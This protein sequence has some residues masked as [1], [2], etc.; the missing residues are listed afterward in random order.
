[1]QE[2]DDLDKRFLG[3][4]LPGHIGKGD[5]GLLFHV[6]LGLAFADAAQSAA[7]ALGHAPHEQAEQRVHND[8]RDDP[9]DDKG[10]DWAGFLDDLFII[11]DAVAGEFFRERRE[12]D[13][14][15]DAR[16]VEL[17]LVL[18]LVRLFLCQNDDPVG[19]EL[20][21]RNL[22]AVQHGEK[23]GI[24]DLVQIGGRNCRIERIDEQRRNQRQNH[25]KNNSLG[26]P[27]FLIVV[28]RILPVLLVVFRFIFQ[29]SCPLSGETGETAFLPKL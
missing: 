7:H 22:S 15:N 1:V 25:E 23:F 21:R 10:H 3:L 19:L 17:L 27:V 11:S 24:G 26:F 9:G 29:N 6:D 13:V 5:A 18:R 28:L 16:V 12:I 2:I 8:D 4:V 14:G 20:D